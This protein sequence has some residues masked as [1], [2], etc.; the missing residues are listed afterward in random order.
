MTRRGDLTAALIACAVVAMAALTYFAHPAYG[1]QGERCTVQVFDPP[2]ES[3][4]LM[5]GDADFVRVM[6][7]DGTGATLIGP[8]SLGDPITHPGQVAASVEKCSGVAPTV[9]PTPTATP[10]PLPTPTPTAT[11]EP[12]STPTPPPT[13]TPI[14]PPPPVPTP[15][16]TPTPTPTATPE[17]TATPTQPT[18]PPRPELPATGGGDLA[19]VASP[20]LAAGLVL[21]VLSHR[22]K[23]SGR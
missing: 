7:T 20:L 13:A 14:I 10:E 11:P 17:P 23:E 5:P 12:T 4:W 18:V 9:P 22:V 2:L 19:W 15:T 16:V 3:G 6:F 8:F 21:W 1:Q